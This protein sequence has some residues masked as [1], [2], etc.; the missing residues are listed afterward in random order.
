MLLRIDAGKSRTLNHPSLGNATMS[1]TSLRQTQ[2]AF[3]S[4]NLSVNASV[5]HNN[6]CLW[7][8]K[9]DVSVY[10]LYTV[11]CTAP[12][13]DSRTSHISSKVRKVY[14]AIPNV[15]FLV[16]LIRPKS[17]RHHDA[18]SRPFRHAVPFDHPGITHFTYTGS[19]LSG[20]THARR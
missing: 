19:L 20:E 12:A 8:T 16:W 7:R 2:S 6:H 5:E 10:R 18:G 11:T 14:A 13:K 15:D 4:K 3:P 17:R 9:P 1:K